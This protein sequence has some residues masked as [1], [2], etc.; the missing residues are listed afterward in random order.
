MKYILTNFTRKEYD[1]TNAVYSD[2]ACTTRFGS[3]KLVTTD[4]QIKFNTGSVITDQYFRDGYYNKYKNPTKK[5]VVYLRPFAFVADTDTGAAAITVY[6]K[7]EFTDLDQMSVIECA[8]DLFNVVDQPS[9]A[10]LDTVQ[11]LRPSYTLRDSKVYDNDINIYDALFGTGGNQDRNIPNLSRLW[12]RNMIY[13]IGIDDIAP[14]TIS[15]DPGRVYTKSMLVSNPYIIGNVIG[16][17]SFAPAWKEAIPDESAEPVL[18]YM[19]LE[20][21]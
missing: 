20:D 5:L 15:Q 1:V 10:A 7:G 6:F 13:N 11:G 14:E 18:I 3:C 8:D 9:V 12:T 19:A 17:S 2:A 4:E 16:C 21:V